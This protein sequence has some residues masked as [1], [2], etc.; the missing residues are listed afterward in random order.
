MPRTRIGL[1]APALMAAAI[2]AL[3]P[4]ANGAPPDKE[5]DRALSRLERNPDDPDALSQV[6]ELSHTAGGVGSLIDRY[7]EK[8]AQSPTNGTFHL[9]AGHLQRRAGECEKAI[10]HYAEAGRRLPKAAGPYLG[11]AECHRLA[12]RWGAAIESY[13]AALERI[14]RRDSK[15]EVLETLIRIALR[16]ERADLVKSAYT[17]LT[18]L[19]PRNLFL[20]IEHARALVSAG[21][22][23]L[24]LEIWQD[25]RKRAGADDKI[26]VLAVREIG[27]LL[28]RLGQQNAAV[29]IYRNTLKG[30]PAE[31]WAQ[32]ELQEGLIAVYRRQGRLGSYIAELEKKRRSYPILLLLAGLYEELGND[33]KA[34]AAYRSAVEQRPANPDARKALLR[35]LARVGNR[36]ELIEEYKRLIRKVPHEP[37]YELELA[38]LYFKDGKPEQ[39]VALLDRVSRRYASDAAIHESVADLLIR[40]SGPEARI[41]REYEQLMRLEPREEQHVIQLGEFY[42]GINKTAKA[43]A[44]WKKLLG[45]HAEKSKGHLS[46]AQLYGD[47]EMIPEA[48]EHFQ[49]AIALE[50]ES[51]K[52][53]RTF[54]QFL[55]KSNRLSEAQSHW[56]KVAELL[57]PGDPGLREARQRV[58]GLM[59]R[60]GSLERALASLEQT[61]RHPAEGAA[62]TFLLAEGY[63]HLKEFE[64]AARVLERVAEARPSDLEALLYLEDVYEKLNRL[65]EAIETL[66]RIT[67]LDQSAARPRLERLAQLSMELHRAEDALKYA[68]LVTDL[69]PTDANAHTHLGDIH[70]QLRNHEAA[71]GAY[72]RSLQLA[73]GSFPVQFKLARVLRQL[74]RD[75]DLY[76]VLLQI[77]GSATQPQDILSAGRRL[78]TSPS[79]Q[80]LEKMEQVLLQAVYRRNQRSVYRQLL[81]DLYATMMR[82]LRLEQDVDPAGTQRKLRAL[83]TQGIKPILDSLADS[84]LAV[85]TTALRVLIGTRNPSAG[86]PLV[87]MLD[88]RDRVLRF[89]ALVA[90]AHIAPPSAIDPIRKLTSSREGQVGVGA[91]WALGAFADKKAGEAL[92][93]ATRGSR[94]PSDMPP[95]VCLALGARGKGDGVGLL[96]EYL[97]GGDKLTR[98]YAAWALGAIGDPR[99]VEPLLR[100]LAVEREAVQRVIIWALG[101]IGSPKALTPLLEIAVGGDAEQLPLVRWAI[102]RVLSQSPLDREP[103]REAYLS[104]HDFRQAR[105]LVLGTALPKLMIVGELRLDGKK[106]VDRHGKA[107]RKV[108]LQQLSLPDSGVRL[109]ILDTISAS[110]DG[111]TGLSLGALAP[112]VALPTEWLAPIT[113]KVSELLRDQSAEVRRAAARLLGRSGQALALEPLRAALED[114]EPA[115]RREA[116]LGIAA[117]GQAEGV[118]ALLEAARTSALVSTWTGRAALAAAL[119]TLA[120]RVSS[121]PAP[122]ANALAALLRDPYPAVRV[123]ALEALAA[124]GTQATGTSG[125]VLELLRDPDPLV[126]L[127]SVRTLGALRARTAIRPLE[128]LSSGPNPRLKAAARR[129]LTAIR[130]KGS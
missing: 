92:K 59:A 27:G 32:L 127:E 84:D 30:L 18:S 60:Q 119:A 82:R 104:L 38:E 106:L 49:K 99:A 5:L 11:A 129:A 37:E 88:E 109:R 50:K 67:K 31:H 79:M 34:L 83:G 69:S 23:Q 86:W 8:A 122:I 72:R 6:L 96:V 1:L 102:A 110:P 90:L 62:D 81:V 87:R 93:A 51:P 19:E 29:D 78:M 41:E 9:V 40:H 75:E 68:K 56:R 7:E 114:G 130:S 95:T 53:H 76:R 17:Q 13:Q 44:V 115:V 16:A 54:A 61:A 10:S 112:Q 12:E 91:A 26:K 98:P 48:M 43:K 46:L 73:P 58:V 85:R 65:P 35:I 20:R 125:A 47:H 64:K 108:L 14:G 39:A 63:L 94:M 100:R 97:R 57:G 24:A 89:Q 28:D 77:V 118:G 80:V 105:L 103:L 66:E 70:L 71:L 113:A 15:V 21:R 124:L 116:A 52:L 111:S 55:E 3:P 2:L 36:T 128:T 123:A 42:I 121:P 126:V 117:L 101:A 45:L 120:P 33:K 22:L 107:L 74:G 4:V 25:I